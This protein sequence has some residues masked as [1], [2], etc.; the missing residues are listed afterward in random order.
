MADWLSDRREPGSWKKSS[1]ERR[2][3]GEMRANTIAHDQHIIWS[4]NEDGRPGGRKLLHKGRCVSSVLSGLPLQPRRG[5]DPTFPG[6]LFSPDTTSTDV[7]PPFLPHRRRR[8]HTS[9]PPT[10][11]AARSSPTPIS[12]GLICQDD[13][14]ELPK[15]HTNQPQPERGALPPC[16]SGATLTPS[17]LA[18]GQLLRQDY[19][20]SPPSR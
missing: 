7:V 18:N 4:R 19:R 2:G 8:P 17:L 6:E 3:S 16:H 1:V 9:H 13:C 12:R 14:K 20:R 10:S 11:P 5:G 15:T